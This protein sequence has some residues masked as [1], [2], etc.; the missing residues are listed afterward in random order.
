MSL[1]STLHR[2]ESRMFSVLHL[3]ASES[4]TGGVLAA[5]FSIINF[6]QMLSFPFSSSQALLWPSRDAVVTSLGNGLNYVSFNGLET[7]LSEAAKF[8][9]F[10]GSASWILVFLGILVLSQTTSTSRLQ[11]RSQNALLIR[12]LRATALLS[13]KPLFLPLS[14]SLLRIL[15]C[16]EQTW[17]G[18]AIACWSPGH[19]SLLVFTLCILMIFTILSLLIAAV[20][21]DRDPTSTSWNA[22]IHGRVDVCMLCVKLLLAFLYNVLLDSTSIVLVALLVLASAVVWMSLTFKWLPYVRMEANYLELM[23]GGLYCFASICFLLAQFLD[24]LNIGLMFLLAAVP[25][26]AASW[27]IPSSWFRSIVLYASEIEMLSKSEF[28][29]DA[30]VS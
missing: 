8:L 23:F 7:N 28:V 22:K 16:S 29:I 6:V 4:G 9:I 15:R 19:I 14:A 2:L 30:W 26:A 13:T 10:V 20:V 11:K 12:T 1:E 18:T 21:I 5:L 17:L 3:V 24:E 27:A 25:V